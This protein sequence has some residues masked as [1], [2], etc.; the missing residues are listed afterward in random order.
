MWRALQSQD[1]IPPPAPEASRIARSCP[2][3]MISER[4]RDRMAW[5]TK[6]MIGV[7]RMSQNTVLAARATMKNESGSGAVKLQVGS[8]RPLACN[9]E[10][11]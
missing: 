6:A 11:A 5:E 10:R 4:A 7:V 2:V 1:V 9:I 3:A 8:L